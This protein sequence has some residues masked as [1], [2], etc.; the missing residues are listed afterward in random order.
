MASNRSIDVTVR[1]LLGQKFKC[2][3]MV[4]MWSLK[5]LLEQIITY[6]LSPLGNYHWGDLDSDHKY[7]RTFPRMKPFVG[8]MDNVWVWANPISA[9]MLRSASKK[10][11]INYQGHNCQPGAPRKY[12]R[13][14]T[15]TK[16][17]KLCEQ[18]PSCWGYELK[19][20]VGNKYKCYHQYEHPIPIVTNET[21]IR[22]MCV[23]AV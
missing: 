14:K 19:G 18:R 22:D 23:S 20:K 8:M 2:L 6:L 11:F 4:K 13:K 1:A 9:N 12:K 21:A 10:K 16:C 15:K 3:S 17:R 5:W 7:E